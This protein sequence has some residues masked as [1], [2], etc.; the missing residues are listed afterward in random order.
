MIIKSFLF[1]YLLLPSISLATERNDLPSC[2]E[3]VKLDN[4]RPSPSGRELVLIID[5]TTHLPVEIKTSAFNH[6]IRFIKPGDSLRLYRISAFMASNFLQLEYVARLEKKLTN[7]VRNDIGMNT[8][9]KLDHC[10]EQQRLAFRNELIKKMAASFGNKN[11][12]ISKS[13]ILFSLQKISHE[14]PSKNINQRSVLIVSDMLENSDFT[15][16]YAHDHIRE[17]KPH[18]ELKKVVNKNL[19]ADLDGWH[20]YVEAA[21]VGP[22]NAKYGYRS[23]KIMQ[24][25]EQFWQLY[26]ERSGAILK[27]FGTPMLTAE[28]N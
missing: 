26:F 6:T 4:I 2:Y 14:I 12:E 11:K 21:G 8:L 10:L 16:F 3:F 7:K 20:V 23:G 18:Q 25:L 28:I 27:G 5:E 13:E 9:K 17:I 24:S 22:H 1:I 19:L 15:T